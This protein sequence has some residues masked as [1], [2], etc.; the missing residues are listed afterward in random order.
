MADSEVN[1]LCCDCGCR[2]PA[3]ITSCSHVYVLQHTHPSLSS[4]T[5]FLSISLVFSF[6]SPRNPTERK[7]KDVMGN[8]AF[9]SSSLKLGFKGNII[10]LVVTIGNEWESPLETF[11]I[12][13]GY[14]KTTEIILISQVIPDSNHSFGYFILIYLFFHLKLS[15]SCPFCL[16]ANPFLYSITIWYNMY[17]L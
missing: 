15:L 9:S 11:W 10:T 4:S 7:L 14:W 12:L 5:L 1:S 6:R 8:G 13:P 2:Y 16:P 17:P 3:Q